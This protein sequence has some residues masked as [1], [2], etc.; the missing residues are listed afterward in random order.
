MT[1]PDVTIT[2]MPAGAIIVLDRWDDQQP[3]VRGVAALQVEPRRWWLIDPGEKLAAVEQML[4]D[5]GALT[6]IGGGL[7][8]AVLKG[9]GWRAQLMISGL[10]DAEDPSFKPGDCAATLIHHTQV[11]I[12]AISEREAHVYLS[13][14]LLG[15]IKHL[16]GL[17]LASD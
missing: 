10:F 6:A 9:P 16:W 13:A 17:D 4:G 1:E 7:M 11:W 12:H 2:F 15:D 8:R 5:K 14:S 3:D